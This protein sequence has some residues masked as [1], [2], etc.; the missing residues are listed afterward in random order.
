[1]NLSEILGGLKKRKEKENCFLNTTKQLTP[2]QEH[3]RLSV[4]E[5][6]RC[7]ST[8]FKLEILILKSH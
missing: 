3:S 6:F 8:N 7:P 2:M 4:R 5:L 1:M